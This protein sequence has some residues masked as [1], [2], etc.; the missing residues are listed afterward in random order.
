MNKVLFSKQSEQDL[1]NIVF[2]LLLWTKISITEEEALQYADDIYLIAH[3]I[4][5][6]SYHQ[7]CKYHI[8]QQYGE[9]QLK[10]KRNKRTTWYIIY[11]IEP[12]YG[13]ILINKIINNYLTA[14]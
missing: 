7:K 13:N 6:L 12:D 1:S 2:G 10:Y 4:P 5:H 8:H 9:Y 14:E 3:S 11:D